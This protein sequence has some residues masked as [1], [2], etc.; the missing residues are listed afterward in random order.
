MGRSHVLHAHRGMRTPRSNLRSLRCPRQHTCRTGSGRWGRVLQLARSAFLDCVRRGLASGHAGSAPAAAAVAGACVITR[1][2]QRSVSGMETADPSKSAT[3]R[4][5]CCSAIAGPLFVTV[6][7]VEGAQ[8]PD[9]KPLRHPV[10]SLA[11]G[12]RGSVQVANFA[13]SPRPTHG[14]QNNPGNPGSRQHGPRS[15]SPTVQYEQAHQPSPRQNPQ[16][17]NL[18]TLA[19]FVDP[20]AIETLLPSR[21]VRLGQAPTRWP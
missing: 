2:P 16:V 4:L 3:H 17:A 5:L 19:L 20:S 7:V 8:R 11:L 1:P 13:R 10:S 21:A 6:F 18:A 9:Y 14:L 15:R 12:S